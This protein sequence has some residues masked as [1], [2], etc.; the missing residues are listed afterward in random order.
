MER[1]LVPIDKLTALSVDQRN[2]D[3]GFYV[4]N[5]NLKEIL[6]KLQRQRVD[7]KNQLGLKSRK[8]VK[9][10]VDKFNKTRKIM[11][12]FKGKEDIVMRFMQVGEQIYKITRELEK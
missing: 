6:A 4:S 3:K 1:L 11:P 12:R 5:I 8:Q 9:N 7:L 10:M 2:C